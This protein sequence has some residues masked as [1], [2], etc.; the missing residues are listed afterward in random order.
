MAASPFG[1]HLARE[2]RLARASALLLMHCK[3]SRFQ[4]RKQDLILA[5]TACR[6]VV[7]TACCAA[8]YRPKTLSNRPYP[9]PTALPVSLAQTS[10]SQRRR[11]RSRREGTRRRRLPQRVRLYRRCARQ[12]ANPPG[13]AHRYPGRLSQDAGLTCAQ[14]LRAI[15]L[16]SSYELHQEKSTGSLE[17]GKLADFIVLDRDLFATPAHDVADT[18]VLSTWFEGHCVHEKN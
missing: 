17:V 9:P 6:R 11:G 15:A 1:N 5:G 16:K 13:A 3:S 14:T 12:R 18:K 4:K 10:S 8:D 7:R 2:G